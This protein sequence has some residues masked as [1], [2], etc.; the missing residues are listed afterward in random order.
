MWAAQGMVDQVGRCYHILYYICILPLNRPFLFTLMALILSISIRFWHQNH[1]G[2]SDLYYTILVFFFILY[3]LFFFSVYLWSRL[4]I[5]YYKITCSVK[6]HRNLP[7]SGI[8]LDNNIIIW[9]G[10]ILQ[11]RER[12][13]NFGDVLW[14]IT[15][16][17]V[18]RNQKILRELA[19][20]FTFS[21]AWVYLLYVQF[22]ICT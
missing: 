7:I 22:Q 8:V 10:Q 21:N 20:I 4:N 18:H 5:K 12:R 17:V 9:D 14:P 13:L 6:I 2:Q 11:E 16:G 3:N 19:Y 1:Q 15:T